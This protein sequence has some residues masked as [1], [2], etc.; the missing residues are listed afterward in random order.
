MNVNICKN[1][2]L[3]IIWYLNDSDSK[4]DLCKLKMDSIW[5]TIFLCW[6]HSIS[7]NNYAVLKIWKI[8]RK[9][10][11]IKFIF[12]VKYSNQSFWENTLTCLLTYCSH[13]TSS[14]M[15][16][17]STEPNSSN[18]SAKSVG[19]EVIKSNTAMKNIAF[20]QSQ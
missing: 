5:Q 2:E 11:I 20:S 16:T 15:G 14:W 17:A 4:D 6:N 1:I 3:P 10:L 12:L 13:Y 9:Y 7:A 18:F 19:E 8:K